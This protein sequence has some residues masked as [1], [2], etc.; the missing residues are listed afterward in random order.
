GQ[1]HLRLSYSGKLGDHKDYSGI[2]VQEES[3]HRY[4]YTQ[5]QPAGAREAFPHFDQPEFKVPWTIRITAPDGQLALTNTP[6][7]GRRS[8]GDGTTTFEF[9]AS[10]PVPSYLV[11][12]AVGPFEIVDLGTGGRE[13]TPMRIIVPRGRTGETGYAARHMKEI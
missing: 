10:K 6:E 9:A 12:V 5:F 3:G 2:F 7:T 8:N 11:A 4:I 1:V 13:K